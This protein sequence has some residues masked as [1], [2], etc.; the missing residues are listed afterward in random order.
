M[1]LVWSPQ[2]EQ[3]HLEEHLEG[4]LT[5]QGTKTHKHVHGNVLKHTKPTW[6][7]QGKHTPTVH[8]RTRA[9]TRA[10]WCTQCP[11]VAAWN[12]K[13]AACFRS[14]QPTVSYIH[15]HTHKNQPWT[16]EKINGEW[17]NLALHPPNDED[18]SEAEART[19][20]DVRLSVMFV[21][22]FFNMN[23]FTS[24]AGR[25]GSIIFTITTCLLV[26]LA[27]LVTPPQLDIVLWSLW[28]RMLTVVQWL[29]LLPHSKKGSGFRTFLCGFSSG[30][31]ASYH[32]LAYWRS[33]F[34]TLEYP[35][36]SKPEW[37]TCLYVI[38]WWPVQGQ[39][40]ASEPFS[41]K[42]VVTNIHYYAWM[43]IALA[44]IL[45]IF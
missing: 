8:T 19:V 28:W 26:S 22:A 24:K 41:A 32:S 13:K 45:P 2:V 27:R 6:H 21:S 35:H 43:D 12:Q 42:C 17:T 40:G 33:K 36:E 29:A 20:T 11:Q 31:P 37:C 44:R 38:N 30:A 16:R 10:P 23:T 7:V 39:P 4:W 15:T 9:H 14:C 1:A 25:E 3:L 18:C 34:A 5:K